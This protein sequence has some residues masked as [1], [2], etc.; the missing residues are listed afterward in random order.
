MAI[1]D[2]EQQ[3][4]IS[5]A[6]VAEIDFVA[7]TGRRKAEQVAC[8]CATDLSQNLGLVRAAMTASCSAGV[9]AFEGAGRG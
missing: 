2:E 8:R 9:S 3:C 4:F 5:S 1:F 6:E 7:F